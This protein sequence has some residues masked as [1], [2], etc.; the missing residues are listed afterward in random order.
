M[1]IKFQYLVHI[2]Y[3]R[4]LLLL[5]KY[6]E[7]VPEYIFVDLI[8]SICQEFVIFDLIAILIT[9]K[10]PL[11][12]GSNKVFLLTGLF[13]SSHIY[14]NIYSFIFSDTESGNG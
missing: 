2:N 13:F 10:P 6:Y 12:F 5:R 1:L 14:L 3:L 9:P 8:L 11:S 7:Y 4:S